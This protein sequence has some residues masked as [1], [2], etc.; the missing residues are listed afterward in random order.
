MDED[1]DGTSIGSGHQFGYSVAAYGDDILVGAPGSNSGKGRVYLFS[2]STG[3]LLYT[4]EDTSLADNSRFGVSLASFG[5]TVVVGAP[6]ARAVV[7][8]TTYYKSGSVY[9]FDQ[10][11]GGVG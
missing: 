1:N 4:F 2:G 11:A 5:D 9:V 6:F 8:G 3:D 7:D 10:V